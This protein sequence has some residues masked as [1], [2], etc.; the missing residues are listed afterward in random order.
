MKIIEKL[1]TKNEVILDKLINKQKLAVKMAYQILTKYP[2]HAFRKGG[3]WEIYRRLRGVML[4]DEVGMGKTFEAL[5]LATRLYLEDTKSRRDKF[6]IL[7]LAAPA[8]QSKWTWCSEQKENEKN[9]RSELELCS[10]L[11]NKCKKYEICTAIT[12]DEHDIGKYLK[13]IRCKRKDDIKNIFSTL[14]LHKIKGRKDWRC[15]EHKNPERQAVFLAS[16]QT[17]PSPSG[18][19][20]KIKFKGFTLKNDFFNL[21][22]ADEA[23]IAK[24]GV[25]V[26]SEGN[27]SG[28]A[29]RKIKA[30]L[31]HNLKAKLLLLTAT[32]FQNHIGEFKR[33]IELLEY[34]ST[35]KIDNNKKTVIQLIKDGINKTKEH[36]DKLLEGINKEDIGKLYE[37]ADK[38]HDTNPETN[39]RP[40]E[41]KIEKRKIIEG[42][43]DYMRDAIV[44][45]RKEKIEYEPKPP[46]DISTNP[47]AILHYLLL[48]DF[49]DTAK[50]EELEDNT[51]FISGKLS[52]LVSSEGA[53]NQ[54]FDNKKIKKIQFISEYFREDNIFEIKR[55]ELFRLLEELKKQPREKPVITVFFHFLKSI[56]FIEEHLKQEGF[57]YWRMTG[58]EPKPK[59]R[60]IFLERINNECKSIKFGVF[61]VSQVGNEGLD[62]DKFSNTIIHYDGHYNPAVIDQRNGRVYRNENKP[63]DIKAFRLQLQDTYDQRITHIE[64][65]KRKLKDF[66]LGDK[67][68]E[69]L[70][71][72]IDKHKLQIDEMETHLKKFIINLEPHESLIITKR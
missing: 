54:S 36:Y 48:R 29:I 22:I 28:T 12:P 51:L 56:D 6:R 70:I 31:N 69:K 41:L 8:I 40:E 66:Y 10:Q 1:L 65:E 37:A 20:I 3:K 35:D 45:N 34:G 57:S 59:D 11:K 58:K 61:L 5:A 13:G 52:Q 67:T 68:L 53:F 4:A 25:E 42:L 44:R 47:S 14:H 38:D 33:L 72:E 2:K 23:H 39:Y 71:Q 16:L 46:I 7:I 30:L 26:E 17:F 19:N 49:V 9:D 63:E 60:K 50:K 21:I 55:K 24:T 32:P 64:K 43:D 27:L 15:E 18:R 62:F